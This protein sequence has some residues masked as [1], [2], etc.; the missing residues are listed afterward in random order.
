MSPQAGAQRNQYSAISDIITGARFLRG[1][2][3]D[4]E[5]VEQLAALKAKL[6][7]GFGPS[8]IALFGGSAG[9]NLCVC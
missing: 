2:R 9:A 1:D 4:S 5:T 3:T 7:N 6:P 8:R